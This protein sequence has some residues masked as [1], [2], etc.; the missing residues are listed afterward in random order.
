MSEEA[1][2]QDSM[3]NDE[4]QSAIT[5]ANVMVK[6]AMQDSPIYPALRAH[7]EK[8]LLIQ[9]GRAARLYCASYHQISG[10]VRRI[11]KLGNVRPKPANQSRS[12]RTGKT[13]SSR[14][15]R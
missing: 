9:Q 15:K 14:R 11:E 12:P 3:S 2:L 4:L 7:L 6:S 5:M 13:Q 10:E 1:K 8:L